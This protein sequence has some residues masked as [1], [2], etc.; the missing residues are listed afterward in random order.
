[1]A[2]LQANLESKDF[3]YN[4]KELGATTV[5]PSALSP[6]QQTP[7]A[8]FMDNVFPCSRGY[9]SVSFTGHIPAIP[10]LASPILD[11]FKITSADGS[12]AYLAITSTELW[13]FDANYPVWTVR[14]TFPSSLT[15]ISFANVRGEFYLYLPSLYQAVKYDFASSVFTNVTLLG[16]DMTDVSGISDSGDRMLM[17]S[18]G[19][20]YWSSVFDPLDFIPSLS[21]GAGSSSILAIRSV[22]TAVVSL[23]Q[24][25]IIYTTQNAVG[26]RA[27][28]DFNFPYVFKE[29]VGSSGAASLNHIAYNSNSQ[30]HL[31]WTYSGFQEVNTQSAKYIFPELSDGIISGAR[32]NYFQGMPV[33]EHLEKLDVLV[34]FCSNRWVCISTK[35]SSK[36]YYSDC[37]VLDTLLERW[38][39]LTV[40]H[41]ALL[42]YWPIAVAD[43]FTYD[44]IQGDFPT[45]N[46]FVDNYR[47]TF[48]V[49]L[50][51]NPPVPGDNFGLVTPAGAIFTV[52]PSDTAD[53][54]GGILGVSAEVS[55][56]IFGKYKVTRDA[57]VRLE[58]IRL[59]QLHSGGIAAFSHAYSGDINRKH[60]T[61]TALPTQPGTW[62]GHLIGD[63]ISVEFTGVFKITALELGLQSAGKINLPLV[64]TDLQY[65]LV[66]V[67]TADVYTDQ[68]G[69]VDIPTPTN[70]SSVPQSG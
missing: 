15:P 42:E 36:T 5:V 39:K 29:I 40:Q 20:I 21:T 62:K 35:D 4:F 43:R 48:G 38:G 59:N 67:E 26:A 22:I 46:D 70:R 47:E 6:A 64:A 10:A 51:V 31:V 17:Y 50:V 25:F 52:A 61:W 69:V 12:L 53:Y 54:R 1:M 58:E 11:C 55:R 2:M 37:Y 63:S 19:Q 27:T 3:P 34:R 30:V 33:V 56:I 7:Q 24:D 14:K 45:Y 16:I 66:K 9:T 23:G 18:Y 60:S 32:F 49:D 13:I 57:G 44:D 68:R 8:Y 41:S 65:Q 28:G